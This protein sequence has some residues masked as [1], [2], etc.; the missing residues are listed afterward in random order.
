MHEDTQINTVCR[1]GDKQPDAGGCKYPEMEIGEHGASDG[2]LER[3]WSG[4]ALGPN[5]VF[6]HRG[7]S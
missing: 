6:P 5:E 3:G 1:H 2:K 4:P 7:G